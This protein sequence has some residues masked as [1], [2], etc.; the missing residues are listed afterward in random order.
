[1]KLHLD[2]LG[3]IAYFAGL[4]ARTSVQ[5][6]FSLY[7]SNIHAGT[8][9]VR[10]ALKSRA[11]VYLGYSIIKDTGGDHAAIDPTV[12]A[13]GLVQAVQTFPVSYQSPSARLSIRITP[14]I[15]WNA[16]YQFYNYNEE[17]HIFTFN[18][19]FRANTGYT[20]ILWSF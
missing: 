10:I 5:S 9:G 2:T 6:T 7:Q 12:L 19:N 18:Q 16:G 1:M 3:G 8:L 4:S 17:I 11:D 13:G 14:K 15:R 20:S